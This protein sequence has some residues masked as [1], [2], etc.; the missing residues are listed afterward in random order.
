MSR[1]GA[2]GQE[3]KNSGHLQ[4]LV[5]RAIE[6]G[7]K[8][9]LI[10]LDFA[11]SIVSKMV[12]VG[13]PTMI[14]ILAGVD[15]KPIGVSPYLPAFY[16]AKSIQSNDLDF[17]LENFSI[18]ILPQVSGSIGG[19]ILGAAIAVDMENQPEGTLLIDL[20]TNGELLLSDTAFKSAMQQSLRQIVD[21]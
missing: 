16:E 8:E 15:P 4:N 19:D 5:V 14:H 7:I 11:E 12:V 13:N 10:S 9:L 21:R 2:I 3:K 1:I 17:K 18:Q 6:W 20:G